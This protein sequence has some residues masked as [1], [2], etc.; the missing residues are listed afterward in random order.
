M[1]AA[2]PL[3][4]IPAPEGAAGDH[5][6]EGLDVSADP[7]HPDPYYCVASADPDPD[8]PIRAREARVAQTEGDDPRLWR[9]AVQL[10]DGQGGPL[11]QMWTAAQWPTQDEAAVAAGILFAKAYPTARTLGF[12]IHPDVRQTARARTET[13]ATWIKAPAPRP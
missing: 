8:R 10:S 7:S 3:L 5:T 6:L 11:M 1:T 9:G 12:A 13:S 2:Y 4:R